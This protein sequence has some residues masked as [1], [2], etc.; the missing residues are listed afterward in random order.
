MR[1]AES[2]KVVTATTRTTL[3]PQLLKRYRVQAG[4][5]QEG[6]AERSGLSTRA[7]SDLER[8]INRTP[9]NATIQLLIE[10]LALTADEQ[11]T[12]QAAVRAEPS[13]P[14]NDPAGWRNYALQLTPFIG[15]EREVEQ[16]R[17]RLLAAHVRLLTLTGPGGTGKTRLALEVMERS[18]DAFP[19]GVFFIDL[20]PVTDAELVA[21]AMAHTLGTRE[22]AGQHVIDSLGQHLRE[23]HLLLLLDNFEHVLLAASFLSRLLGACPRTKVLAT[24]RVVLRLAGEHNYPVPPLTLPEPHEK[25]SATQ[26]QEYEAVRL[27]G[28][29]AQAAKP[30]FGI[31]EDNSTAITEICRR[32]DGLPLALELAAARVRLLSPQALLARLG[33]RLAL[34]TGGPQDVPARQR[35]LRATLDWSYG[36]LDASERRLLQRLSVFPGG[37]GLEA[38]GTV[39]GDESTDVLDG[40]TSLVDS[41]LLRQEETSTGDVRFRLLE[42]IREYALARLAE[43]SDGEATCRRQAEYYLA[44]VE[45]A[46]PELTGVRQAMWLERLEGE[47]D[48]LSAVLGWSLARGDVDPALRIGGGLWRFWFIR[49]YFQEWERWLAAVESMVPG[50]AGGTGLAKALFGKAVLLLREEYFEQAVIPAAKSLD[51]YRAAGDRWGMAACLVIL[52]RVAIQRSEEA[53]DRGRLAE[54]VRLAREVGEPW[55]LGWALVN[56]AETAWI[57]SDYGRATEL[58]EESLSICRNAGDSPGMATALTLLGWLAVRHASDYELAAALLGEAR[59]IYVEIGDKLG[60][61]NALLGLAMVSLSQGDYESA[62]LLTEERQAV[63]QRLGNRHGIAHSNSW[64]G[65]IASAQG[66]YSRADAHWREAVAI[67]RELGEQPSL[68]WVL[69]HMGW[70]ALDRGLNEHARGYFEES[71]AV[72]RDNDDRRGVAHVLGGLGALAWAQPDHARATAY[73]EECLALWR[74][75]DDKRGTAA[76]LAELAKMARARDSDAKAS[77]YQS[78]SRALRRELGDRQ[79]TDAW[80]SVW[81]DWRR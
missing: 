77:S 11:A 21:Q 9:R 1:Q 66:D 17:S 25:L 50:D 31:T 36:L 78:E 19:D 8:G 42:T 59:T 51:L 30:N 32:L 23:R 48:N 29:R 55:L 73:W 2:R 10:A 79:V 34:L 68:A 60:I 67:F 71:L 72:C 62:R 47:H 14:P 7:V 40:L 63:E 37:C 81:R 12:L 16:V 28:A 13:T 61:A 52:G 46:E 3:F 45:E 27:F 53:W 74:E 5:T 44:L 15:R 43:S 33:D 26:V 56:L 70:S 69:N 64:L 54:S 4:L 75:L 20:A 57:F 49:G 58:F 65:V 41:S 39:C 35:T 22:L 24:S 18:Q 76:A 38:A 80:Q 6:L